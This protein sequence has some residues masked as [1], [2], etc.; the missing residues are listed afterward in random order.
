MTKARKSKQFAKWLRK[1]GHAWGERCAA[2]TVARSATRNGQTRIGVVSVEL[3]GPGSFDEDREGSPALW[4][5]SESAV[6]TPMG[7]RELAA[8]LVDAADAA[9]AIRSEKAIRAEKAGKR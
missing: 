3:Y 8:M 7:A 1:R 9:D 5:G 2:V 4:E 6:L